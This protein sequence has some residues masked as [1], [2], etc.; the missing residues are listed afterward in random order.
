MPSSNSAASL[1]PD[2][3][4]YHFFEFANFNGNISTMSCLD[5]RSCAI[6][7]TLMQKHAFN[8]LKEAKL[9]NTRLSQKIQKNFTDEKMNSYADCSALFRMIIASARAFTLSF[10][11]RIPQACEVRAL[12]E[13]IQS[14][15]D[16]DLEKIWPKLVQYVSSSNSNCRVDITLLGPQIREWINENAV[17]LKLPEYFCLSNLKIKTLPIEVCQFT[18]IRHLTMSMNLIR[19]VPPEIRQLTH[20]SSL[21]LLKNRI[22]SIPCEIGNLTALTELQLSRNELRSIPKEIGKLTNLTKLD[23]SV[24]HLK[25]I[26]EEIGL[27]VSLIKL[28]ISMNRCLSSVP[29]QIGQ[30]ISLK[31]LDISDNPINN[32]PVE[33]K[34]LTQLVQFRKPVAIEQNQ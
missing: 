15:E 27:L 20:L 23:L 1:F 19:I 2:E 18:S 21:N 17:A 3:I 33:I 34:K 8:I 25:A 16:G 29:L 22:S 26:P 31:E 4:F 7:F 14:L 6:V 24:N 9:Q 30:L 13:K 12:S 5:K 32:L 11:R 10:P 28:D